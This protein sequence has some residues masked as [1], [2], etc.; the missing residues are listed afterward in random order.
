MASILFVEETQIKNNPSEP[1][2]KLLPRIWLKLIKAAD[3]PDFLRSASYFGLVA[4]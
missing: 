3:K 1:L 4:R 2:A